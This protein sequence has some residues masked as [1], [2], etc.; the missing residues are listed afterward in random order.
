MDLYA[1]DDTVALLEADAARAPGPL[2]LAELAWHLRQRDTARAL[3][4]VARVEAMPGAADEGLR[5]RLAL[6]RA[7]C[8]LLRFRIDEANVEL[9][10]L[11]RMT[12]PATRAWRTIEGD[13]ALLE[14]A[15]ANVQ[16][17][18]GHEVACARKA[19]EAFEAAEEPLRAAIARAIEFTSTAKADPLVAREEMARLKRESEDRA[20]AAHLDY[21]AGILEFT[22]GN[23]AHAIELLAP[24]A[25]NAHRA[26]AAEIGLRSLLTI[27]AAL[28]N[29][30]DWDESAQAGERGLDRARSLGWPRWIAGSLAHLGRLFTYMEQP[31]RAV[32]VLEE[33]VALFAP[34]PRSRHHAMAVFYLGDAYLHGGDGERALATLELSESIARH[35]AFPP[36]L[37]ANLAIAARALARVGRHEE[38]LAKAGEALEL[39]RACGAKLW[40]AEALRSFAQIHAERAPRE[41]LR[42][43]DQALEV[44]DALGGHHEKSQLWVE[45]AR[46][47]ERSGDLAAALAAERAA[48]AE[49]RAEQQ[50]RAANQVLVSRMRHE[51]ESLAVR[52]AQMRRLATTD[53]LTGL[54]NR[55]HFFALAEAEL[56]RARR[57]GTP[58]GLIMGDIDHFK[59]INDTHGHP[60]GDA[61]LAA[62]ARAL[63]TEA[64]P[65][66][67]VGRLGGE[68]FAVLLPGADLPSTL[69]V[70]E[71]L[72]AAIEALPVAQAGRA[73]PVTISLGCTAR[74]AHELAGHDA[75]TSIVEGMV[76][77]ADGAL[78]VAKRGGRNRCVASGHEVL[79]R[80]A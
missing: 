24:A 77:Q 55:R 35:L 36:E 19:R 1:A 6:T 32:E 63:A 64:R 76:R 33:S 58:I 72:R 78:Y 60:A 29:L 17:E 67:V 12:G 74:A 68:E 51:M 70:G 16:G 39:A 22:A 45:I 59:S 54:A 23:F 10:R 27:A 49:Q 25:E 69:A 28:S 5:A 4:C 20:L 48:R 31:G 50:R 14:A 52:E 80:L 3:E 21:V 61:V 42:Y 30:G 47:H 43:L 37:A 71:R 2:V 8:L 41:A 79:E 13:V 65:N 62:V 56:A 18:R 44:S 75:P 46:L 9:A 7:E 26:G 38:A 15:I 53:A 57:H 40:E 66:D 11:R 34:Q 73:I